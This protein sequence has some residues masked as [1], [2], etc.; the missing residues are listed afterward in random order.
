M[1]FQQT[2]WPAV[3]GIALIANSTQAQTSL[4]V[5]ATSKAA[6]KQS[7]AKA[8]TSLKP[9]KPS[10]KKP[11][12]KKTTL[13]KVSNVHVLG[14]VYL[15][16][17]PTPADMPLLKKQGIQTVITLR[18]PSEVPWDE[19]AACKIQAMNFVEVPFQTP[20]E[21]TVKVF[22]QVRK[23]LLNKKRGPTLFHCGSANRVGAVWYA[24]RILDGHLSHEAALQEAQMVGLRTMPYLRRAQAYVNMVNNKSLQATPRSQSVT[25]Q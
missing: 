5:Q 1:F 10:L 2:I 23:V 18:K 22:D 14:D 9:T 7:A 15:A 21:L 8:T 3:M 25:A 6:G 24:H 17:Q 20:A 4:E 16:G 11:N 13:G 12:L 19:G